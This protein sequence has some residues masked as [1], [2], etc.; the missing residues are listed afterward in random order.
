[1]LGL[2]NHLGFSEGLLSRVACPVA[3]EMVDVPRIEGN[4]LALHAF[5]VRFY[6]GTRCLARGFLKRRSY[7]HAPI[8]K[9]KLGVAVDIIPGCYI[10]LYTR[11]SIS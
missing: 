6:R 8:D 9:R 10:V 5:C 1:M 2:P 7:R 4:W 11:C 3:R